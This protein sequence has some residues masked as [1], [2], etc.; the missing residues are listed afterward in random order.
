M[1]GGNFP[2]EEQVLDTKTFY[3]NAVNYKS[4]SMTGKTSKVLFIH[5][6]EMTYACSGWVAEIARDPVWLG[7]FVRNPSIIATFSHTSVGMRKDRPAL[8]LLRLTA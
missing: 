8:P 4:V 5:C 2:S 3:R 1:Q 6:M 7:T